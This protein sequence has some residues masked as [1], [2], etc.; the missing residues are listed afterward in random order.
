MMGKRLH[1]KTHE[2]PSVT[3]ANY[4]TAL[5]GKLRYNY[6]ITDCI[7]VTI[8]TLLLTNP[9]PRNYLYLIKP[10]QRIGNGPLLDYSKRYSRSCKEAAI[11]LWNF[12]TCIRI[13]VPKF[14]E[15][16]RLALFAVH[17]KATNLG[18]WYY[19]CFILQQAGIYD[20]QKCNL[21]WIVIR[22]S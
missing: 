2:V 4:G 7:C 19:Y 15:I 12:E 17:I 10:S 1:E 16:Y 11:A 6:E 8:A 14:P 5:M 9:L 18:P 22:S 3:L 21:L 13:Y 20:R